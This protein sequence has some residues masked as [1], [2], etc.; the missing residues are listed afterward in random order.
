MSIFNISDNIE[1]K[2]KGFI[3]KDEILK[4]VSEEDIFELIFGFKP[5]EYERIVSPFREDNR[6]GC[7]FHIGFSGKLL[8][9]DYNSLLVDNGQRAV[10]I[11]CFSA[12]QHYYKLES[13]YASLRFIKRHLI[14]GK[15]LPTI[16]R[17]II[18]RAARKETLIF[19]DVRPF[20]N[21]DKIFWQKF[22]ITSQNLI[23]DKVFA[24]HRFKV[25]ST[26]NGDWICNPRDVCYAYTEFKDN[27]KKIYRPYQKGKHRFITNCTSNDIGGLRT[28]DYSCSQLIITKSYKDYRVLLNQ[29]KNVIWFQNEVTIPNIEI[30]IPIVGHFKE[31]IIFFDNDET[32]IRESLYI[33]EVINNHIPNLA[34][35]LYLP[36]RYTSENISDPS[37]LIYKKGE[38]ILNQFLNE[39]V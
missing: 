30:L 28:L 37:D 27:K 32:G 29:G 3:D 6:P 5:V 39:N 2:N 9:C 16:E 18:E 38:I 4:Y 15:N 14:D 19:L 26:K 10:H 31:V 24:V 35:P 21:P 13:L 23:D 20:I 8:F 11:D 36:V 7:W 33:A 22:Q 1:V 17:K 12:I 34:R 25:T